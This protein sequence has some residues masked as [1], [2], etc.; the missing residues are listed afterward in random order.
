M[1]ELCKKTSTE[2]S[3]GKRRVIFL[4]PEEHY[5]ERE[6]ILRGVYVQ[7]GGSGATGWETQGMPRRPNHSFM[8]LIKLTLIKHRTVLGTWSIR[9][10]R[11]T[12]E[13][14]SSRIFWR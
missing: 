3:Y 11:R 8:C 4:Q 9:S 6:K 14:N 5:Q 2:E 13:R 10:H 1:K 7:C 12:N